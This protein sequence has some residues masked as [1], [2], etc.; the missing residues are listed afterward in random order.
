MIKTCLFEEQGGKTQSL[1][2]RLE[3]F[4][5]P[6]QRNI[7]VKSYTRLKTYDSL[8]MDAICIDSMKLMS[9]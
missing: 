4:H 3:S 1:E 7:K 6:R 9:H 5:E 2:T 8:Y